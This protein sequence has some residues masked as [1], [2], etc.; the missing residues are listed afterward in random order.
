ML[1]K[2]W[3]AQEGGGCRTPQGPSSSQSGG[4]AAA[5]GS[6]YCQEILGALCSKQFSLTWAERRGS[7]QNPAPNISI[8]IV[9]DLSDCKVNL[10]F[11]LELLEACLVFLVGCFLKFHSIKYPKVVSLS[12]GPEQTE[13][14]KQKASD[15]VQLKMAEIYLKKNIKM[16]KKKMCSQRSGM[17][18]GWMDG[19]TSGVHPDRQ[20]LMLTLMGWIGVPLYDSFCLL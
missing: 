7:H 6:D 13:E 11:L 8:I 5:N 12:H 17:D 14:S 18:G 16:K 2:R 10:L 3:L 20:L 4:E 9:V 19:A 15:P 1:L